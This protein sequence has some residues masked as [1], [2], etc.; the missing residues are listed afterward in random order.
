[1]TDAAGLTIDEIEQ[2]IHRLE[3]AGI[4]RF[5]YEDANV[6]LKLILAAGDVPTDDPGATIAATADVIRTSVAGVFHARH[7]I[8][9]GVAADALSPVRAGQIVGYVQVGPVARPVTAPRDGVIGCA[10]I[11]DGT[12]VGAGQALFDLQ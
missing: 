2:F 3:R 6:S 7:P 12:L 5:E 10:L 9:G 1:M 8:S 4:S 11:Q